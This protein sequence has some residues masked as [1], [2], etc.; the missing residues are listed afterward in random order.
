MAQKKEL[1]KEEKVKKEVSRIK[2][3]FKDM[4]KD[5]KDTA[6]SLIR[7]AA[8]MTVTLD[9]LQEEINEKG[10]VSHY[11]NGENQWGTKK[12]PEVEVYNTMIKNHMG[13]IKQ[14]CDLLP[15]GDARKAAT[16]EL[17]EFVKGVSKK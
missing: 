15:D 9:E 16:D 5:R 12:S 17:M 7:N 8:F 1:S 4:P 3:V 6:M 10:V 11:Q 13:V 2:R 14:L